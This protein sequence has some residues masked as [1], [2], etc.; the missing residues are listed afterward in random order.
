MFFTVNS[1]LFFVGFIGSRSLTYFTL[2]TL[3]Y[4]MSLFSL[5]QFDMCFCPY[6]E[7]L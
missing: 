3:P 5:I 4:D 7:C 2:H 1:L 6:L